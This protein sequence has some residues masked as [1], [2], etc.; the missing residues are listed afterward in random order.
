MVF[1]LKRWIDQL[2]IQ[3]ITKVLSLEIAEM[4]Y[5]PFHYTKN[6]G[7]QGL[8][9]SKMFTVLLGIFFSKARFL[10]LLLIVCSGEEYSV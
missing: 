8:K 5:F 1:S 6:M 7:A 3:I 10:L 2:T 4:L 9:F